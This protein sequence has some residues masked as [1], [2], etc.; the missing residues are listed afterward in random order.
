MLRM[1]ATLRYDLDHVN[2]EA[3]AHVVRG[4]GHGGDAGAVDLLRPE[5][6][7]RS[8]GRLFLA[9]PACAAVLR[10]E[11][12]RGSGAAEPGERGGRAPS[13][14]LLDHREGHGSAAEV[15]CRA[16]ERAAAGAR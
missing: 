2:G 11:A 3:D 16:D 1:H 6:G 9:V 13:A 5:A 12:A 4:P 15:A 7:R 10:A 14:D 8:L